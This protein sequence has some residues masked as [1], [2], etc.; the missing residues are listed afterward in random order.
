MR[1]QPEQ[2][3]IN[4]ISIL[5]TA[6]NNWKL[7]GSFLCHFYQMRRSRIWSTDAE[8]HHKTVPFF[9]NS[10][11]FVPFS[12][13]FRV[14]VLSV[15]PMVLPTR[16]W[17]KIVSGRDNVLTTFWQLLENFWTTFWQF[18]DNFLTALWQLLWQLFGLFLTTFW[19]LFGNFMWHFYPFFNNFFKTFLK[20]FFFFSC[21]ISIFFVFVHSKSNFLQAKLS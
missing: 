1:N 5:G 16:C 11:F 7:N 8:I 14:L 2:P 21:Q 18:L 9:V 15:C 4:L 20:L 6:R 3:M 17:A 10:R 13:I 12:Q 19:Q